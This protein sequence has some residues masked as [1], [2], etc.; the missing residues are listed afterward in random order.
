M[1]RC[2][3]PFVATLAL[4]LSACVH[5][6]YAVPTSVAADAEYLTQL[7]LMRGHLLV[8]HTLF[9]LGEQGMAQSH[10][11]HPSDE[12]YVGIEASFAKHDTDGFAAELEAYADALASG[13][14]TAVESTYAA[15]T[16]AIGRSEDVVDASPSLTARVIVSIL[17][18]AAA[19]YA[20]GVVDG[21]LEN[22]H[23]YQ[24][25]YGFVQV[26]LGMTHDRHATL[27]TTN[28]DRQVFKQITL[29]LAQLTD[30]W[31]SLVPPKELAQEATRL[32]A[33]ADDIARLALKLQPLSRHR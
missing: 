29:R 23:E 19:E 9:A 11:K 12:L 6:P 33:A 31:P 2:R 30:M 24:D 4:A 7:G 22:V 20:L 8:G 3:F 25:A 13:E 1:S 26:A 15:L 14:P 18:E 21:Q 10:A 5:Q 32:H 28:A 17:R 16:A 27:L